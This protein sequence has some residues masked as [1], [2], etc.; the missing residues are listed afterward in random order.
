MGNSA[1]L[2]LV[3]Q[4]I[5]QKVTSGV[6]YKKNMSLDRASIPA[7]DSCQDKTDFGKWHTLLKK[8]PKNPQNTP[9]ENI[10]FIS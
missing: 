3:T 5:T 7:I 9:F 10:C 2:V 6:T 4:E 1:K 8:L